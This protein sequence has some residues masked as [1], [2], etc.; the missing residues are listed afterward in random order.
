MQLYFHRK[1]YIH[2]YIHVYIWYCMIVRNVHVDI[3]FAC[4][5]LILTSNLSIH[6]CIVCMI[7]HLD[8]DGGLPLDF[9]FV[10]VF[11]SLSSGVESECLFSQGRVHWVVLLSACE[12]TAALGIP[13]L[14]VCFFIYRILGTN[15]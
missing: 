14:F 3:V 8:V 12:F 15:K 11:F 13:C 1:I 6:C 10:L 4:I 2:V 5:P 7:G 9:R